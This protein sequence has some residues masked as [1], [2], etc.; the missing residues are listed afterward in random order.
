MPTMPTT[1]DVKLPS[2]K[3]VTQH[4]S[5]KN[6]SQ[7][8]AAGSDF[9]Q[10][11]M[12]TKSP[13]VSIGETPSFPVK[14]DINSPTGPTA[15]KLVTDMPEK[16]ELSFPLATK[17]SKKTPA[18]K[19][20]ASKS[21]GATFGQ[22]SFVPMVAIPGV[23]SKVAEDRQPATAVTV[24]VSADLPSISVDHL[25]LTRH[26]DAAPD[27][28]KPSLASDTTVSQSN[29]LTTPAT[30]VTT[31]KNPVIITSEPAKA[32]HIT[33]QIASALMSVS[34]VKMEAK[35]PL[36]VSLAPQHLGNITIK[37]EHHSSGSSNITIAA[38]QLETLEA[39][40]QDVHGLN[41]LLTNAGLP[42]VDRQVE[43]RPMAVTATQ[44]SA[45][46]D[47]PAENARQEY[48]GGQNP[49]QTG[50]DFANSSAGPAMILSTPNTA[51]A[52]SRPGVDVIA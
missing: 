26:V 30:D 34:G 11:L 29:S 47:N 2:A 14:M 12:G 38:S 7:G 13:S 49:R 33:T 5:Q 15:I 3:A 37:I 41:Q 8:K 31:A 20:V 25:L 6:T 32:S 19:G 46:L 23:L 16:A 10:H 43:F 17:F 21:R 22:G 40:K 28:K 1:L 44:I 50:T 35:L 42:S 48:S 39:L 18:Q 36:Y 9:Q 27:A 51:F 24:A 45:G 4:G 52:Y